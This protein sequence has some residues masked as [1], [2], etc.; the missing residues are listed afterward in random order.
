MIRL[1]CWFSAS[2]SPVRHCWNIFWLKHR[3]IG[4]KL[5]WTRLNIIFGKIVTYLRNFCSFSFS[6][7][8][9]K[10]KKIYPNPFHN[11]WT[12]TNHLRN[13]FQQFM[14][15]LWWFLKASLNHSWCHKLLTIIF[16]RFSRVKWKWGRER[17][18]K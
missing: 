1:I 8:T 14:V 7:F 6:I 2:S 3:Q 13:K 18:G 17:E 16:Q 11:S 15:L 10:T 5:Q 12:H 9:P 4:R